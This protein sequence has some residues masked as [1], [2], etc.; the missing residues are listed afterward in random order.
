MMLFQ[1][2]TV[3]SEIAVTLVIPVVTVNAEWALVH[4]LK[5]FLKKK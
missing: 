4:T 5:H 1:A 2:V 3:N